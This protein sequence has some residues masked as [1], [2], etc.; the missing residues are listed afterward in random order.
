MTCLH[1]LGPKC[2]LN[3]K[4]VDFH[5]VREEPGWFKHQFNNSHLQDIGQL[6]K[7]QSSQEKSQDSYPHFKER[8]EELLSF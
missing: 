1:K 3:A 2:Y 5:A 8:K 4:Q 6:N 7:A